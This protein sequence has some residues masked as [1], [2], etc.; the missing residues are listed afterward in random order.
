VELADPIEW[1]MST[2]V[3]VCWTVTL[4]VIA[5]LGLAAY[6]LVPDPSLR[7][8]LG[9]R[10][11]VGGLLVVGAG[12]VIGLLTWAL[13][14]TRAAR[15]YG[16][17]AF[18]LETVPVPLGGRLQGRIRAAATLAPD[19]ALNLVLQC[20]ARD[21]SGGDSGGGSWVKW[22]S[23]QLLTVA[24]VE[25]LGGELIVPVDLP[26]PGN[27]PPTG[28]DRRNEYSWHLDMSLEPRSGYTPRFPFPVLRTAESP[29]PPEA[30]PEPTIGLVGV[31]EKLG[32]L[33][34][35]PRTGAWPLRPRPG[36][37]SRRWSARP[38]PG[39]SWRQG[40]AGESKSYC[41]GQRPRWCSPSGSSSPY[42]CGS[43]CRPGASRSCV[44]SWVLPR[45]SPTCCI[46][47]WGSAC[48]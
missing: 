42:R 45:S 35:T 44:R 6:F 8:G 5:G 13:G 24:E 43:F 40:R 26:V 28:K 3:L 30:E 11:V 41:L 16:D 34:P 47:V 37:M 4:V 32:S 39:S 2:R 12:I 38:T 9:E 15:L 36:T 10:I 18:E 23:E 7:R 19:Q 29:P 27:Q 48:R 46:S 22:E 33:R 1:K 21:L 31:L 17:A 25:Q 20:K 14:A